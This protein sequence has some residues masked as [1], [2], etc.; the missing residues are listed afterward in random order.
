MPAP[1]FKIKSSRGL[2]EHYIVLHCADR[3]AKKRMVGLIER[4]P[5]LYRVLALADKL[6]SAVDAEGE[7][8]RGHRA[9]AEAK[10]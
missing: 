10:R 9:V 7:D 1:V 5:Q 3:E 2:Q 4:L 8:I 6:C